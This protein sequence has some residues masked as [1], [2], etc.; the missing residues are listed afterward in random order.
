MTSSNLT[1]QTF[2]STQ[3]SY[4][5]F[6]K[7]TYPHHPMKKAPKVHP[8]M[9]S[10][11]KETADKVM[12]EVATLVAGTSTTKTSARLTKKL[13]KPMQ[14]TS[15]NGNMEDTMDVNKEEQQKGLVW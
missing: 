14:M 8:T 5:K 2:H 13:K 12:T 1:T 11:D 3:A 15:T 10:V 4:H 9:T 6:A 7:N